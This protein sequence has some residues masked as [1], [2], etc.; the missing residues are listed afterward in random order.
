MVDMIEFIVFLSN[1]KGQN[2]AA[3]FVWAPVPD[4]LHMSTAELSV[5]G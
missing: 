4:L 2:T 5:L 3:L 1:S